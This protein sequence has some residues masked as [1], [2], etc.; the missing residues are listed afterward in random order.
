M[1][2]KSGSSVSAALLRT[3]RRRLTQL[4]SQRNTQRG[5]SLVECHIPLP[6]QIWCSTCFQFQLLVPLPYQPTRHQSFKVLDTS[7]LHSFTDCFISAVFCSCPLY[8]GLSLSASNQEDYS[9][10]PSDLPS[11]SWLFQFL[12]STGRQCNRLNQS[13]INISL[14]LW[15]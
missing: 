3:I 8:P 10:S 13:T 15:L 12:L 11:K 9:C 1:G 14:I 2:W 5:R 6:Y 4:W 7:P